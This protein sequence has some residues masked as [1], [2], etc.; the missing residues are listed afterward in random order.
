MVLVFLDAHCQLEREVL[1]LCALYC[2]SWFCPLWTSQASFCEDLM[3]DKNQSSMKNP[4]KEVSHICSLSSS[5]KTK[6]FHAIVS[7]FPPK[8]SADK[9]T[10]IERHDCLFFHSEQV[11]PT[12]VFYS[13]YKYKSHLKLSVALKC[14]SCGRSLCWECWCSGTVLCVGME[15][16]FR[17]LAPVQPTSVLCVTL[18]ILG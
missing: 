16:V 3:Q 10:V 6:T 15:T 2:S 11:H 7:A 12:G 18:L 17:F 4:S 8:E 13:H 14:V 5:V 9:R 1:C